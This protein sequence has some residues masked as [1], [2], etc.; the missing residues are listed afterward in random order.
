VVVFENFEKAIRLLSAKTY[1]C[2]RKLP[3]D[4]AAGSETMLYP[5]PLDLLTK[6]WRSMVAPA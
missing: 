3:A 1:P 2:V 5:P 4:T 6:P